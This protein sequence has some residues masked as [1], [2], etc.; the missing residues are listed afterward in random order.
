MTLP[1]F[2]I[3]K[4]VT[5]IMV[6]LGVVILGVISFLRLPQ[7]LFP[8]ITF[9]QVTIVT[10]YSNAAPEEIETLITRT[11]EEAIGSVSGLKRMES[12]SR[13]GRSTIIVSFSWGQ[14]IDFAALAVREKIDLIKERLPK[15]ADDPVVLKFDPLAKPIMMISVA[16]PELE[17]V[18]L[19][20]LTEKMLKDRLEKIEGVA[21]VSVS[22]GVNREILV[23]ID[24]PRL[25]ANHLSLLEVVDS[26]DEANVSYPAGSIKKGLYEYLIR[27]VGEF[28]SPNEINYAVVGVDTVQKIRREEG[29]FIER[30]GEGP[31]GTVDRLRE[32][33]GKQSFEKRLILTRDVARVIDGLAEQTSVSRYN[34]NENITLS[35]QK[36]SNANTIKLVDKLKMELN[37]L[38][39]D[40]DSR[41]ISHEIIYDHSVFIRRTLQ[42]LASSA[43]VGALLAFIV[44]FFFLRA[45]APSFLVI[46]SIPIT[47]LGVFFLMSMGGITVNIMSLGGLAL[48]IGMIVDTSIVVLENIFRRR[49]LGED[50]ET[51]AVRGADEV[52][53]PVL[54][55]G[56]TTISVFFPLI[57]FVP[58]VPGQIFKDLSWTIVF[59]Q[60]ISMLVPLSLVTMLSIYVH[61]RAQE[62][63]PFSLT[64][65]LD[66]EIIHQPTER[67]QNQMLWQILIVTFLILFTSFLILPTLDREVLPKVD[68]GRFYIKVDMPIGTRL[69]VTDEIC[70]QMEDVLRTEPNIE[71]VATTIGSEKTRRG[72]IRIETLRSSQ[73]LI[74]VTLNKKR[75]MSS[76]KVIEKLR[77]KIEKLGLEKKN[78][79]IE[80]VLQESEFAVAEGGTKPILIEVKGYDYSVLKK[81]TDKLKRKLSVISGVID[82]QDDMADQSPETKLEIN[83]KRAALYGI[84]ALD[85]SLTAKTAIEGVVATQYR[86]GGREIDVRVQLREKDRMDVENLDDLLLYSQVLDTHIS[87]KEI[88]SVERGLGPSEIKR[89]NQERTITISAGIGKGRQDKDV[90]SDVQNFL[91]N[92]GVPEDIPEDYQ[93][94]LSGKAKEVK[95]NFSG[96]IFAFILSIVLVYMI[97][98]SQ[99]E[100][101]L[102]PLLIMVTVPLSFAGA[103]VALKITGSSLNVISLLG[104]VLLGGIVVNNGIVLIE[105]MNQL[106]IEGKEL[107]EAVWEATRI[108]TRPVL[109]TSVTTIV[110]MLPL[111]LGIGEG[112]ELLAPLA[113]TVMG[114]LFSS[115]ILTLLVLPCLYILVTRHLESY[116]GIPEE[117]EG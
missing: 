79:Q 59:S 104:I 67:K 116:F 83:K 6:T 114:G 89:V 23:E 82:V 57:V 42:N 39:E 44:L 98:A 107:V 36:Q 21:S 94:V 56:L 87:L 71:N 22:G 54:A 18:R 77:K 17:P 4:K 3:R 93:V 24:Q 85:V 64:G 2:A 92:L 110:A 13:E 95:E 9:P 46:I 97:M 52:I 103:L 55:S 108:R 113:I 81:L 72:E 58:G 20:L 63:H 11:I 91:S 88:A 105:Y 69:E 99:F 80:F 35:V 86:E 90:L 75:K 61:I 84:S 96:V 102:Q 14:D 76:G 60:I 53:W 28:R 8:P 34:D 5:V 29:G 30:G 1:E 48:A 112:S 66:Q 26:L 70:R 68:Q 12:I 47:I 101:F 38:K 41:G 115:T 27:T 65:S 73:G 111:S 106:R 31:R 43:T 7:E 32:E 49:Q 109:M 78:A 16:G 45:A 10:D 62:Y 100:S 74:L 51:G 25:Q 33:T 117:Y 37:G 19:K 15:E 50:P 40:L